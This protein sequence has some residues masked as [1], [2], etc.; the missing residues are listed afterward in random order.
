MKIFSYFYSFHD[1]ALEKRI[2][3]TIRKTKRK[4]EADI[5]HAANK[6]ISPVTVF[7]VIVSS[8]KELMHSVK[9]RIEPELA[10]LEAKIKNAGCETLQKEVAAKTKQ[11]RDKI[12]SDQRI[13]DGTILSFN[14]TKRKWAN[15]GVILCVSLDTLMNWRS[16]QTMS[17]NIFLSLVVSVFIAIL[18]AYGV[19]NIS[20]KVMKTESRLNKRI[21]I[22]LALAC[23]MIVFLFLG[24]LRSQFDGGK[25]MIPISPLV[26]ALWNITFFSIALLI[27]VNNTPTEEQAMEYKELKDHEKQIRKNEKEINNLSKNLSDA[28]KGSQKYEAR[29]KM[30]EKYQEKLLRSLEGTAQQLCSHCMNEYALSGGVIATDQMFNELKKLQQ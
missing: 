1:W 4:S 11:L 20:I 5:R 30:I 18:L 8:I 29:K 17:L 27:A 28:T 12:S 3:Q 23:A 9:T 16:L 15:I 21:W 22:F 14:W 7:S 6:N 26:W 19:N 13:I 10:K 24:W 2:D 25:G